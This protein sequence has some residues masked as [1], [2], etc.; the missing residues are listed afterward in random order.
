VN[1]RR[2][3]LLC[4]V[5]AFHAAD[6][7]HVVSA[8]LEYADAVV[9]IDALPEKTGSMVE[10]AIAARETVHVLRHEP[11]RGIGAALKAGIGRC[12]EL[13]AD[14]VVTIDPRTV[15]DFSF[16]AVV[17]ALFDEDE[18]L[19]C[20][21]G[22]RFFDPRGRGA[23]PKRRF[24]HVVLSFLT[25]VASGYWHVIDPGDGTL[26]FNARAIALLPWRTFADSPF[27]EASALCELG[28][29]RLPLI[30]LE[31]PPSDAAPTVTTQF[32]WAYPIKLLGYALRRFLVQY[33]IFD[34]NL[35]SLY[36]VA[37]STLLLGGGGWGAYQWIVSLLTHEPRSPGTVMLAVL[38]F[39][40][41]FQL[42]LNAFMFDV[43][44]AQKLS[45]EVLV[46]RRTGAEAQPRT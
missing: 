33:F 44:A 21:K 32:R 30:E 45:K 41:G 40:M 36:F 42:I 17:R 9:V 4:V 46:A 31:M 27:F 29:R 3:R 28:L 23:V 39:L 37:G 6:L 22:N 14:I 43:D 12:I 2:Q 16:I 25:K 10:A 24:A 7:T 34:L 8:A 20:V 11:E 18:A 1:D 13:D 5:P 26:A 15:A 19:V 35:G 38:P